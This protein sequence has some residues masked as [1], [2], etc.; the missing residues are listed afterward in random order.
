VLRF[1]RESFWETTLLAAELAEDPVTRAQCYGELAFESV[2]RFMHGE[3]RPLIEEWIE[4]A[5]A[6]DDS[7]ARALA[8]VARSFFH[9]D[10]AAAVAAEAAEI[11]SGL[12]DLELLSW[13]LYVRTDAALAAND[14]AQAQH[15]AAQRLEL[16]PEVHDPDH[17]A[18]AYWSMIPAYAGSG[19]LDRARHLARLQD[20]VSSELTPHHR[21]HG[22]A[23]LLE[24]EELAADWNQ[25][26]RLIPR[27]EGVVA[28]NL[29]SACVHNPRS[30][31][32]C[33]LACACL[34]ETAEAARL[35]AL[36]DSLGVDEY[37][38]CFETRARL[39][40]SRGDLA[41]TERLVREF[42]DERT[43]LVRV[44]KLAPRA[45]LLD[46]LAALGDSARVEQIA[47]LLLLPGTYLE[48]FALRALGVV[49]RDAGL[50]ER[51]M[52]RFEEMG[53]GW[54]AAQTRV[55]A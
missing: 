49:R 41:T 35:E 4:R 38:R 26:S 1:D 19:L 13:A 34:E 24:V 45:A 29:D 10:E 9:E 55:L 28:A 8:L 42:E 43:R 12:G 39:A 21:V 5:L 16:L 54:H 15:W 27:V 50:I 30:L 46:S 23:T 6:V 18:D 31:L 22:V 2:A 20:S 36:A 47:P 14:Y 32:V 11:A 3:D 17:V 44:R 25:I 48:P 53:L 40:L 7:R 52:E 33:A 37:G 51:A